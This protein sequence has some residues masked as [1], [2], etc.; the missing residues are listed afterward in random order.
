MKIA[1]LPM[2]N[3][4]P[5]YDFLIDFATMYD[6]DILLPPAGKLGYYKIP[7]DVDW[8]HDWLLNQEAEAFLISTEMLCYGGLVASR[9]ADTSLDQ[10]IRRLETL[11]ALRKENPQAL[12]FASSIVR[13]ASITVNSAETENKW[14]ALTEYL[15]SAT[16]NCQ[17]QMSDF[18]DEYLKYY[19]QLRS[20]NHEINKLCV[21][22]V[23]TGVVDTLVL[24]VEDT[25]PH[26]PHEPEVDVLKAKVIHLG[27]QGKVYIHNGADEVMQELLV[28][29]FNQRDVELH[30]DSGETVMR[31]MEFEHQPF[32]KNLLSHVSL[33]GFS[34]RPDS[35]TAILI[36]G[37]NLEKGLHTLE[38]LVEEG[39]EI[40]LLDLFHPNGADE[41]LVHELLS[42][43]RNSPAIF[44][45]GFSAWNTASNRL[46]TLLAEAA[47]KSTKDELRLLKFMLERF[48][49]DYLYQSV[50]RRKLEDMLNSYGKDKYNIGPN[51]D[52]MRVFTSEFTIESN[53]LLNNFAGRIFRANNKT[54]L[55]K[56]ASLNYFALPWNRTFECKVSVQIETEEL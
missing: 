1:V 44:L 22:F 30:F 41:H 26:G 25:F 29:V 32:V 18:D 52:I 48:V 51:S 16:E 54:W 17:V 5:N 37:S 9:E 3:R 28:R 27:L 24:A 50:Y 46:G 35:N 10:A 40:Y 8:L 39:K 12:I 6:V 45:K 14:K 33:T 2:D 55:L 4:P 21:D 42:M 31:I 23:A 36:I 19:R 20:R 34:V 47:W 13:R 11:K 53:N 43:I 56:S 7:G 38:K 15:K 49:D